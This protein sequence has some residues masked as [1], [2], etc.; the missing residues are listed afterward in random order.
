MGTPNYTAPKIEKV[1]AEEE[2]SV[3]TSQTADAGTTVVETVSNKSERNVSTTDVIGPEGQ[4]YSPIVWSNMAEPGCYEDE[5]YYNQVEDPATKAVHDILLTRVRKHLRHI[6]GELSYRN[7]KEKAAETFSFINSFMLAVNNPNYSIFYACMYEIMA[8]FRANP[9]LARHGVFDDMQGP[10]PA[11][12]KSGFVDFSYFNAITD[13]A[14]NML[15]DWPNRRK[16]SSRYDTNYVL[17]LQQPNG[18]ANVER[19]IRE[20]GAITLPKAPKS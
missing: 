3:D 13:I 18:R 4:I 8:Y 9:G 7:D 5:V 1:G 20:A 6:G 2:P 19:F 17:S 16:Y 14:I 10:I 12:Y 15:N 11:V